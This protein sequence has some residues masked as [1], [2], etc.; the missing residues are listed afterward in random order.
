MPRVGSLATSADLPHD[1]GREKLKMFEV[2]GIQQLQVHPLHT[3]F[4]ERRES[5]DDFVGRSGQWCVGPKLVDI[6]GDRGGPPGNLG[7]VA[8]GAH[9]ERRREDDVVG[10]SVG[11][12]QWVRTRPI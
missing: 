12:L 5:V 11:R 3:G 4:G 7:V 9:R 6:P 8:A 1:L 2:P 10:P